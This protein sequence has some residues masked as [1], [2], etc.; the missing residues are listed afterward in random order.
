MRIEVIGIYQTGK[1]SYRP[2]G[3]PVREYWPVNLFTGY[4]PNS[5][6]GQNGRYERFILIQTAGMR[7]TTVSIPLYTFLTIEH[8]GYD[9]SKVVNYA[10][11]LI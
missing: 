8:N 10:R 9:L 5:Y 4:R 2:N 6:K 1:L 3:W 7:G 11:Q